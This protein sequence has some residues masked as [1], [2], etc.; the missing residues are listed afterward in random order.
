MLLQGFIDEGALDGINEV[1]VK[2]PGDFVGE[3]VLEE[4]LQDFAMRPGLFEEAVVGVVERGHE[5]G[6]C[7]T[8]CTGLSYMES[9]EKRA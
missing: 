3:V 4:V 9:T 6:L 1:G 2:L 7:W 8:K 5:R